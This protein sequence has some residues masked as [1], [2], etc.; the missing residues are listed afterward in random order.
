MLINFYNIWHALYWLNFQH[1]NYWF[2]HITH[3]TAAALP[4]KRSRLQ[5][6]ERCQT[7]YTYLLYTLIK[8][9]VYPHNQS[10]FN[11]KYYSKCSKC[12]RFS[13][14]QAW[15][16]LTIHQQ[17]RPQCFVISNFKCG[18][19]AVSDRPLPK[20]VSDTRDPASRPI[21]DSKLD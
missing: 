6:L 14:T 9:P 15:S 10:A 19:S 7:S 18:S 1:N 13:F 17:H 3:V 8:H 2:V 12:P 21:F 11:S 16:L 5:K 20:L 4:C